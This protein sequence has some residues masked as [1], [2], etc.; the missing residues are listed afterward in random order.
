MR[1]IRSVKFADSPPLVRTF[2]DSDVENAA[3]TPH[4][5]TPTGPSDAHVGCSLEMARHV[6]DCLEQFNTGVDKV[7]QARQMVSL[8]SG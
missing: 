8:F 7:L 5:V 2:A 4:F 6:A 3:I 1:A